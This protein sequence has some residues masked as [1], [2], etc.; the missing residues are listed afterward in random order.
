M[1]KIYDFPYVECK[2][3]SINRY[4]KPGQCHLDTLCDLVIENRGSRSLDQYK[5]DLRLPVH[6]IHPILNRAYEYIDF[7]NFRTLYLLSEGD[8]NRYTK[9]LAASGY[10]VND[11]TRERFGI[12]QSRFS[13]PIVR[14]TFTPQKEKEMKDIVEINSVCEYIDSLREKYG[15]YNRIADCINQQYKK[16]GYKMLPETISRTKK[17]NYITK[18]AYCT[19]FAFGDKAIANRLW[20]LSYPFVQ[21]AKERSLSTLAYRQPDERREALYQKAKEG[22]ERAIN[23]KR[24]LKGQEPLKKDTSVVSKKTKPSLREEMKPE[25]TSQTKSENTTFNDTLDRLVTA[26]NLTDAFN[27]KTGKDL[28]IVDMMKLLKE[29]ESL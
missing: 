21:E 22:R 8:Y 15:S 10:N 17:R 5:K 1:E 16:S 14:Y 24:A 29:T 25:T 3:Q 6:T 9:L 11:A 20:E 2:N 7:P 18:E 4:Y 13:D 27:E 26:S 12:W 19:M 23:R 28:S